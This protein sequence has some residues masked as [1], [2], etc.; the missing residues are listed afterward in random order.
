MRDTF[1]MFKQGGSRGWITTRSI[2]WHLL[3]KRSGILYI[4]P[5]GF[6][7]ES[8]VPWFMRWLIDPNRGDLLLAACIHDHMLERSDFHIERDAADTNWS[9]AAKAGG[10]PRWLRITVRLLMLVRRVCRGEF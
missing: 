7:F 1:G 4:V 3:G 6:E 2:G 5:E 8:S 10:A 9:H